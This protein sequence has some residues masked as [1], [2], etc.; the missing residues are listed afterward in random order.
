MEK[1]T[2]KSLSEIP[3]LAI[4]QTHWQQWG[5][6]YELFLKSDK[7]EGIG[8]SWR[9]N[10]YPELRLQLGA[11]TQEHCSFCDGYPLMES[12]ETV[13]HYAPKAAYP[14]LAYDWEN[15]YYCCDACQSKSNRLPFEE[16]LRP[17]AIDYAFERYFYYADGEV[18]VLENLS[19]EEKSA[20]VAFLKRYGINDNPKRNQARKDRYKDIK[21]AIQDA[22]DGRERN[23]FPFRYV[24]DCVK[25]DLQF[26]NP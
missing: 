10:I 24:F 6:D 11:L 5:M 25:A 1:I 13:E 17:D 19:P 2:R 9:Q 26:V 20:A 8:F 16:S 22:T 21:N 15:L 12:K 23:D 14:L 7:K 18:K 4:L 3:S